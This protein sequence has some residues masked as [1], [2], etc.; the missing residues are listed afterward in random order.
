MHSASIHET[1]ADSPV[2]SQTLVLG[3]GDRDNA[4]TLESFFI[5]I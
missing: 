1:I 3:T 4:V 5:Q 2:S